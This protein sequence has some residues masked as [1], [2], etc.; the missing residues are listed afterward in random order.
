MSKIFRKKLNKKGFTLI[1]LIVVIAILGILAA[2]ALPRLGAFRDDAN[3]S[4]NET[5]A[6]IIYKAIETAY[7][8]GRIADGEII[9][10]SHWDGYVD[11]VPSNVSITGHP[12]SDNLVVVVGTGTA[13]GRY[14]KH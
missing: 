8:A 6:A 3:L 4:K 7:A 10:Q 13:E 5:D 2:I 14:P 11:K 9:E 1:E 12:S